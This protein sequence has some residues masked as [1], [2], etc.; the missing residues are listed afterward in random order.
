MTVDGWSLLEVKSKTG[1][2]NN[3]QY[4]FKIRQTRESGGG[5]RQVILM[6]SAGKKAEYLDAEGFPL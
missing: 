5:G 4:R 2:E 6:K 1:T 3:F